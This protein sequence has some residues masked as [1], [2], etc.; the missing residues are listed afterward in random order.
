MRIDR[1]EFLKTTAGVAT[2]VALF[3]LGGIASAAP[4]SRVVDVCSPKWWVQ[5]LKVVDFQMIRTMVDEG[6]KRLVKKTTAVDAWSQFVGAKDVVGLKFNGQSRDYTKSNRA[7]RDAIV[8]SLEAVGVKRKNIV[9]AEGPVLE[10]RPDTRRQ[11]EVS[12]GAGK[13]RLTRFIDR[14][15]DVLIDLPDLKNHNMAGMTGCLKN[16]SHAHTVMTGPSRFHKNGCD[17]YIAEI[18]ALE[19]IKSKLRLSIMTG[20]EGVFDRG[21]DAANRNFRWRHDGFLIS[22]DPVALDRVAL[23]LIDAER[24][25]RRLPKI[26]KTAK[27]LNTAEKL[28]FRVWPQSIDDL[29]T[30]LNR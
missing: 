3:G 29:K 11:P 20:L 2:G 5:D 24:K 19:P 10:T 13:T 16:L 22:A 14:Q 21:P 12:F 15:I 27:H 25:K 8:A 30:A 9:V 7:L 26:G 4:K 23:D 6:V 1:R 18:C 17:P 28:G